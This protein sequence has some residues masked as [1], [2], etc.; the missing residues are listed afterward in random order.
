MRHRNRAAAGIG[1]AFTL[2]VGCSLLAGR[3]GGDLSGEWRLQAGT[4]QGHAVP[5]VPAAAIT[6]KIHGTQV[7][8]RAACNSYGGKLQVNGSAVTISELTQT[9]MACVDENVMASEAAYLAALAAV[10]RAERNGN[11]LVLRGP[12]VEL[13]FALVPPVPDAALI[14]PLWVLESLIDGDA[15]SSTAGQQAILQLLPDGKLT[16]TTGCRSVTGSYTVSGT[17][18]EVTLDPFDTIGCAAGVGDQD[19]LVLAVLGGGFE[20]AITG[21]SMTLTAGQQG[22]GY[23]ASTES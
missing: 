1:A 4:N 18:V 7:G 20:V 10:D 22:L 13:R 23:R 8:G 2:L 15:V 3:A 6:L 21:D 19:A 12:E 16:A 9:E 5:I 14:G 11:S 17:H